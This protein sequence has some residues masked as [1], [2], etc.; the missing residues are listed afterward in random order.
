[1]T[2]HAGPPPVNAD[3]HATL[4][5]GTGS[6]GSVTGY[7]GGC[8][9]VEMAFEAGFRHFDVAPPYGNGAAE[10]ILGDV[11]GPVRQQVVLV[12]KVGFAHPRGGGLVNTLRRAAAPLKRALPGLWA[13]AAQRT[14]ELAAPAGSFTPVEIEV[15]LAES[16]KRLRTDR[17]DALLLH[18]ATAQALDDATVATLLGAQRQG[19]V[20]S[21]GTG[22]TGLVATLALQARYP[23]WLTWAQVPH[24]PAAFD[25]RLRQPNLRLC[26]HGCLRSAAPVLDTLARGDAAEG[27]EL[28]RALADPAARIGLV[29]QAALQHIGP[30]GVVVVSTTQPRHVQELAR[31]QAKAVQPKIIQGMNDLLA[32]AAQEAGVS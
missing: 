22:T 7:R 14:R 8:R 27:S 21:L 10:R 9:L 4:G 6:L 2:S 24:W 13:R 31:A 18:E 15:S 5:F 17:L 26:T 12:S 29:V 16:L 23:E 32:L 25:Q 28:R 3:T 1:M 30:G 19:L 11:L 20:G